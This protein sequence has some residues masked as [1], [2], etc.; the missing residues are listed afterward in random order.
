MPS[1]HTVFPGKLQTVSLPLGSD[2]VPGFIPG[3]WISAPQS[4]SLGLLC[5]AHRPPKPSSGPGF[6]APVIKL[7]RLVSGIPAATGWL[8]GLKQS[9]RNLSLPAANPDHVAVK[10]DGGNNVRSA[11]S[12]A[13][14]VRKCQL[15]LK[16]VS[17]AE[18]PWLRRLDFVIS[19]PF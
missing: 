6:A 5:A 15:F 13:P 11:L 14:S 2:S 7:N 16:E 12:M 3:H 8:C 1:A 17:L 9:P 10:I 18:V 4:P 19:V